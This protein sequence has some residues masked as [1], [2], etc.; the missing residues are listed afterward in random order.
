MRSQYT[1]EGQ[2]TT[3]V[4]D[5]EFTDVVAVVY[6]AGHTIGRMLRLVNPSGC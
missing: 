2:Q 3:I 5:T 1:Y 6:A 4:L